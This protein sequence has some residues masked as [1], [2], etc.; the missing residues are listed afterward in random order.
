MKIELGQKYRDKVTGFEGIATG[1]HEWLTGCTTVT[2]TPCVDKD[3][4]RVK[5]EGFDVN[6]LELVPDPPVR[7]ETKDDRGGPQC[8]PSDPGGRR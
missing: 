4:K 6:R 1:I 8:A 2:I 5:D 7:V 3:G